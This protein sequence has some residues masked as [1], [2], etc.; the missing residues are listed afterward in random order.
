MKIPNA[1]Q[2]EDDADE[3]NHLSKEEERERKK[4]VQARIR[5]STGRDDGRERCIQ[6]G[7]R[8]H[9]RRGFG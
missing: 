9:Q 3:G 1:E 6:N 5:H 2:Y 7:N 4:I 8:G